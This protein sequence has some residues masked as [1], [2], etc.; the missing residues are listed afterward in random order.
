MKWNNIR[1]NSM[2]LEQLDTVIMSEAFKQQDSYY[3]EQKNKRANL[4]KQYKTTLIEHLE[5]ADKNNIA[6]PL[7]TIAI[8]TPNENLY[9]HNL[10]DYYVTVMESYDNTDFVHHLMHLHIKKIQELITYKIEEQNNE[11]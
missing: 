4:L 11:I 2:Y 9:M 7:H 8:L 6:I 10:I 3:F 5:Y 1:D